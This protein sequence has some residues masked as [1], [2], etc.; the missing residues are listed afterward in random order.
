MAETAQAVQT[1]QQ[2]A[3]AVSQAQATGGTATPSAP[4]EWTS[5]FNDEMKGFVQNK[6]WKSAQEVADSYRNLEKLHGV[7][8]DRLLKLPES[9]E[10]PDAQAIWEKLGKP[11]D[12]KGYSLKVPEKGGDPKL[13]EW[14]ADVFHKSNLTT[15][16]A[17]KVMNAWNERMGAA[18]AQAVENERAAA[19]LAA[20]DLRTEWGAAYDKNLNLANEAGKVLGW[21]ATKLNALKAAIGPKEALKILVDIG[22]SVSES[23]FVGGRPAGDGTVTPDQAKSELAE[24]YK[25]A[26]FVKKYT[27]GDY[28][29][30]QRMTKL[31]KMANPGDH[32]L[33]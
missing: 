23:K 6:G 8:Q 22:N 14:A 27:S 20:T 4:P 28:D 18:Q 29:A 7:P 5:G 3:P 33:T 31:Q 19:T 13:A 17:N 10:S 32:R 11:K 12:A 26:S 1:G 30:V 15:D 16:Q 21:D 25:D 24:L 2:G 9:M